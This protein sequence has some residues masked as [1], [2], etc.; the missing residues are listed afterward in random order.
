MAMVVVHLHTI[1]LGV[2]PGSQLGCLTR[3]SRYLSSFFINPR[4]PPSDGLRVHAT[5]P[6][7]N[8]GEEL[9]IESLPVAEEGLSVQSD[10]PTKVAEENEEPD[11]YDVS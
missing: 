2:S 7:L 5:D 6:D 10:S 3:K 9:S 8:I 1:F 11:A 4:C